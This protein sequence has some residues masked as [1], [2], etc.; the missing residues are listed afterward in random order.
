MLLSHARIPERYSF[1]FFFEHH[2]QCIRICVLAFCNIRD[3]LYV[4]YDSCS[5]GWTS[6]FYCQFCL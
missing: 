3:R 5:P 6:K 1:F 4:K 2:G